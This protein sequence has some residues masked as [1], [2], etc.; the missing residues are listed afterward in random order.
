MRYPLVQLD[1]NNGSRDGDPAAAM[2]Y[3]EIKLTKIGEQMLSDIH[4]NTVEFVPNYDDTELEPSEL[5]CMLPML[6]ANGVEGIAVSMATSI[7]PHNMGE[8]MDAAELIINKT[9]QGEEA[10]IDDL[11]QIIKGP[12]FP[13]GGLM[14]ANSKELKKAFTTTFLSVLLILAILFLYF[15]FK[16]SSLKSYIEYSSL[17]SCHITLHSTLF[18]EFMLLGNLNTLAPSVALISAPNVFNLV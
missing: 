3:T 1:G 8:L 5:P 16:Y 14:I 13:D 12:D 2:R 15:S 4:K 7:P 18:L 10:T 6:L 9:K 11:M 17:S